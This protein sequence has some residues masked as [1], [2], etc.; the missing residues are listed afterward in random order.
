MRI[1]KKKYKEQKDSLKIEMK[2][3][4]LENTKLKKYIKPKESK[5]ERKISILEDIDQGRDRKTLS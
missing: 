5:E 3:L 1:H 4:K 2:K